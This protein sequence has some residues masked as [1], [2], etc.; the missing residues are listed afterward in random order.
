LQAVVQEYGLA[1]AYDQGVIEHGPYNPVQ[2][3]R[4]TGNAIAL[5][6]RGRH[7]NAALTFSRSLERPAAIA[8]QE[9]PLYFRVE[10]L[11]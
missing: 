7:L 9:H 5:S 3:G 8:Q 1:L 10:L 4:M 11:F 2:H 6:A